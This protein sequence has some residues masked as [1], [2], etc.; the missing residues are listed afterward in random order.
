MN[1]LHLRLF[2][3]FCILATVDPQPLDNE[4]N[5]CISPSLL[6][7]HLSQRA[8]GIY[9]VFFFFIIA[10]VLS[11]TL[12]ADPLVNSV[13]VPRS[14]PNSLLVLPLLPIVLSLG[15][16]RSPNSSF[17]FV[18]QPPPPFLPPPFLS[19]WYEGYS[20]SKVSTPLLPTERR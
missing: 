11:G 15:P 6:G 3:F 18:Y 20:F 7:G 9:P 19:Q 2:S 8:P 4:E 10:I 17:L 5:F 1:F 14:L 16:P 12:I 13:L